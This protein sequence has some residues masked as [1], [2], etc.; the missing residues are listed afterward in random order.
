MRKGSVMCFQILAKVTPSLYNYPVFVF[1]Y[2]GW[3]NFKLYTCINC[4][5]LFVVD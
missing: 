5:E 1:N 3:S 4:G 2:E